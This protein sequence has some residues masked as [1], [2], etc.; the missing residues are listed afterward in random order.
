MASCGELGRR[1]DAL[2]VRILG[3]VGIVFLAWSKTCVSLMFRIVPFELGWWDWLN[4]GLWPL[5]GPAV[6]VPSGLYGT[7]EAGWHGVHTDTL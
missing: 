5:A 3:S 2:D 4:I 1:A 7:A 6:S